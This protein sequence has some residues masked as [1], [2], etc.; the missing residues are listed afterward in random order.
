[1]RFGKNVL[2]QYLRTG[3][4]LALFF[5]LFTDKQLEDA[6]LPTPLEARPGIGSLRDAG[7]EQE[8]LIFNRLFQG[9]GRRCLCAG[10]P[11]SG[12]RWGDM[13]L[14]DLLAAVSDVPCV[15][16]QPRFELGTARDLALDLFGVATE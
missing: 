3:C 5:T 7:F 10:P 14:E 6:G 16:L 13:P 15:L 8:A 4:D 11:A 9:F 1:M 2:S 12:H